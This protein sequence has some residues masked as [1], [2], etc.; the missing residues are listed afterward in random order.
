[1]TRRDIFAAAAAPGL[2]TAQSS[3]QADV[4]RRSDEAVERLLKLQIT[5]P[6]E[7]GRGGYR[8]ADGLVGA[9]SGAGLLNTFVPAFLHKD[10]RFYRSG[11]LAE[12]IE[13]AIG[14][15]RK[16]QNEEGNFFLPT[17]NFNSPPDTAFIMLGLAPVLGFAR[18]GGLRTIAGAL[19]PVVRKAGR[20]LAVGGIHTP[21]HRW[22]VCAALAKI[23]REV[24][25]AAY[26]RRIDQWL[27]EGIDIDGDGQFT[28]RSTHQY[29][30][31]IDTA[32]V[33]VADRLKRPEL[34]AYVRRNLDSMLYLMHADGEIVTEISR[35][36]DLNQRGDMGPYFFPLRYLALRDGNRR[37]ASVAN[38]YSSRMSLHLLM[39]YPDLAESG[40]TPE[41]PPDDYE[42]RFPSLNIARI[43]RG[44]LSA[45]ILGE[46]DRFF[47]ARYGD[48]VVNAVRFASAFFGKG[49]F[50]AQKLEQR[51]KTYVLTQDLD[52]GYYQ[53][54]LPPRA[55]A[56]GAFDDT[57]EQRR[58]TEICR[59]RQSAE[60]TE[61]PR[62]F[63]LRVRAHG[64]DDVP[65]A[66]EI[67][68]REGGQLE[69]CE[70][71]ESIAEAWL[72]NGA[73]IYRSGKTTL[74]I[75]PGRSVHRYIRVRGA[76]S[77]LP[78]PS[79]YLTGVTP[80]D[81]TITFSWQ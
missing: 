10:S 64:T 19:E 3:I 77:K 30:P 28:E 62:G 20:A 16:A 69:G 2:L 8:D 49:Q 5:A 65:L 13:L 12:R 53:P 29:N 50:F 6:D 7:R 34:L 46:R 35:R 47:T 67:N 1:M 51:E 27:A 26:V 79:V 22:V 39:E 32:L 40:P 70:R 14:H 23:N 72:L 41:P 15:V 37:Y 52:A 58:R 31:I 44:E 68:L 74:T 75:S 63:Q 43:R 78:G 80:F 9:S 59:L 45:T 11:I 55:V 36:Q 56:V 60:I 54:F 76:L 42:K 48:S 33:T 25:D 17:T 57:R 21:N 66:V 18:G 81:H 61:I 38:R 24:P 71:V 73:A 4:V